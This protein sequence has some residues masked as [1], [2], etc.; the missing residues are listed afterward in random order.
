MAQLRTAIAPPGA[1]AVDLGA[2]LAGV[3]ASHQRQQ[4]APRL[5]NRAGAVQVRADPDRLSAV[6][7]H[8]IQ[9]AQD[10]T[11]PTGEIEVTLVGAT[12]RL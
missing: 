4:P 12:G 1:E 2:L 9:N 10:A 7:G 11:P 8:V 3:V 5:E 6:L